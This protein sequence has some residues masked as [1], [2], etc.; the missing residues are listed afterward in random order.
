[1]VILVVRGRGQLRDSKVGGPQFT[2]GRRQEERE[3]KRE[4]DWT[5]ALARDD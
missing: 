3:E 4:K 1:M 2:Q 5:V